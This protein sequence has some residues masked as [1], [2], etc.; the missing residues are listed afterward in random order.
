[1]QLMHDITYTINHFEVEYKHIIKI[2]YFLSETRDASIQL[3]DDI[4]S[5]N[6]IEILC[7]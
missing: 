6:N 4:I 1:M 7:N 2:N 5:D 3:Y